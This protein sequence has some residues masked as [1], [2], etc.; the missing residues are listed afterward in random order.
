MTDIVERLRN[1]KRLPRAIHEIMIEAAEEIDRLRADND[2]L[3]RWYDDK[4]KQIVQLQK[5]L[6][7]NQHKP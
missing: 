1:H 6:E 7:N 2:K 3:T 4:L 5:R